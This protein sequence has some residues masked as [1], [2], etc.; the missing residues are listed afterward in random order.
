MK[1]GS[2]GE[3]LEPDAFKNLQ[4]L[5]GRS[6]LMVGTAWNSFHVTFTICVS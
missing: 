4:M 5:F 6:A 2:K 1:D 3:V